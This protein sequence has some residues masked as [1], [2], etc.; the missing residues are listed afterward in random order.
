MSFY[1]LVLLGDAATELRQRLKT[2]I[3]DVVEDFGL[4]QGVDVSIV[5]GKPASDRDIYQATVAVFFAGFEGAVGPEDLDTA[6]E[7]L[8]AS[9]PVIPVTPRTAKFTEVVPEPL[10]RNN[11]VVLDDHDLTALAA[12][13]L[14][15][16]GLL[17]R[18]RRV[19]I[20]Y[21]RVESREAALQLHDLLGSRGF[22]AFLDTHDVRPGDPFQDVLW[23]RLC[24]SD[25]V[26]MLDTPTY[27]SSKWTRQELGRALAKEIHILRV[28]WPAHN[29][30]SYIDLSDTIYIDQNELEGPRGPLVEKTV[31]QIALAVEQLRSRSIAARHMSMTGKLRT[32]VAKLGGIVNGVGAYRAISV[33]LFG[34]KQFWVYP[35]V[36]IPTA[37]LFNDIAL[38]AANARQ[39]I[40]LLLYDASGIRETWV[41]H[42]RWLDEQIRVVKAIKVN[43]AAFEM[44]GLL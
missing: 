24:D 28:V 9:V 30:T 42:L 13:L 21:R 26:V 41:Q 29:G 4:Q 23:H 16:L 18:Q 3:K 36:G 2:T 15:C 22:D 19:F 17:R 33:T 7:L 11:G 27:F 34:D 38:K 40:P 32:E 1:E 14:E 12:A 43:D 39:G 31:M 44:A 37:D 10:Q 6:E 20:S 5:D 8:R 35:V 25:V